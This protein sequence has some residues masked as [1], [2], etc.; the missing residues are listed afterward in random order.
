MSNRLR[1]W[2]PLSALVMGNVGLVLV[3]LGLV[4]FSMSYAALEVQSA[5]SVK[6]EEAQVATLDTQY[7]A[8][9]AAVTE[10]DPAALGYAAPVATLFGPGTPATAI[11]LR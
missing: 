11:N 2:S 3:Y 1:N 9:I 4:A 5:Q 7:L 8:A 6:G 10:S